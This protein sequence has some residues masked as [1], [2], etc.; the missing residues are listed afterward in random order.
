MKKRKEKKNAG[1]IELECEKRSKKKRREDEGKNGDTIRSGTK[2]QGSGEGMQ[3]RE[4]KWGWER[5]E[6]RGRKGTKGRECNGKTQRK[7]EEKKE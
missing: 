6:R 5:G 1:R 4:D 3:E 2:S 7:E